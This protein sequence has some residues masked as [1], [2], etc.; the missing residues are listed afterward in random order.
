[1]DAIEVRKAAAELRSIWVMGNEFLQ[2]AAPWAV[3]K[4]DPEQAASIARF[5]L[6]LIALYASLSSPFIPGTSE[7]MAQAMG[8]D[9]DWPKDAVDALTRLKPGAA[10]TVPDNLFAKISDDDREAWSEKFS[11]EKE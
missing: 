11:G 6:N 8:V 4:E 1:M 5:A 10:F 7:K 3:F 9:L 2:D